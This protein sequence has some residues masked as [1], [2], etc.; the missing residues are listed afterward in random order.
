MKTKFEFICKWCN[1]SFFS[2]QRRER[3]FCCIQH[4]RLW[5]KGNI[6]KNPISEEKKEKISKYWKNRKR[7]AN[8]IEHN[9][10]IS[11]ARKGM[12]FSKKHRESMS[13]KKIQSYESG[14]YNSSFFGKQEKYISIKTKELNHSHSSY[15]LTMM[16][17]FDNNSSIAYWTKNHKIK[18]PYILD[19]NQHYYIPDFLITYVDGTKEIIEVKG[20]IYNKDMFKAKNDACRTF[21]DNNN[22]KFNILFK[23][24]I[25]E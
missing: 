22:I 25:Y 10:K 8:S 15:E 18:I 24:N 16:K 6:N 14:E 4:F 11:S 7:G 13:L 19:E 1:K 21:C 5:S 23:E 12:K 3:K 20:Y 9:K 2:K 17:K